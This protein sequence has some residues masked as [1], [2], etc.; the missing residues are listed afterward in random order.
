MSEGGASCYSIAGQSAVLVPPLLK[1][2]IMSERVPR[3]SLKYV[4]YIL[5][6]YMFLAL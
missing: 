6:R 1:H 5:Q 4:F 2:M 3:G